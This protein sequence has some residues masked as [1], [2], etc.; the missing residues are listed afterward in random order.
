[1]SINVSY[2]HRSCLSWRPLQSLARQRFI[3]DDVVILLPSRAQLAHRLALAKMRQPPASSLLPTSH[4][5][6]RNG[7]SASPTLSCNMIGSLPE[8]GPTLRLCYCP[9]LS[10]THTIPPPTPPPP[11]VL[12]LG[13][14]WHDSHCHLAFQFRFLFHSIHSSIR[15][16]L[17]SR[18]L[19]LI[20]SDGAEA[21]P[22]R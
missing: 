3:V 10:H 22:L 6:A 1:M 9:D 20:V 12:F 18:S 15:G 13:S 11:L 5:P 19:G 17:R 16:I 14:L 7:L 2:S 4:L 21:T 8:L